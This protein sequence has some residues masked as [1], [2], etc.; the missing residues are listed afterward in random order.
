M[1][2]KV[3]ERANITRLSSVRNQAYGGQKVTRVSRKSF[4]LTQRKMIGLRKRWL[5]GLSGKKGLKKSGYL[6]L[7]EKE[8]IWT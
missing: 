7:V 1:K 8:T 3:S 4:F 2:L 5:F 6:D